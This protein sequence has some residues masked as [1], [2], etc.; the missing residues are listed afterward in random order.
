VKKRPQTPA[1]GGVSER[2]GGAGGPET[3]PA[4]GPGSQAAGEQPRP[5]HG[6]Q[7]A[8]A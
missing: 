5:G 3:A 7:G 2:G 6:R 8:E 1:S 4:E